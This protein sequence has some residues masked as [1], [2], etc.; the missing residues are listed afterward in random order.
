M[1]TRRF[2]TVNLFVKDSIIKQKAT[3]KIS[4]RESQLVD[5]TITFCQKS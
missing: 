1:K 2:V 5:I 3:K 4:A